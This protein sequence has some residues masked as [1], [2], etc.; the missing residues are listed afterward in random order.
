MR[1]NFSLKDEIS[2]IIL[3]EACFLLLE[4]TLKKAAAANDPT[5]FLTGSSSC[6]KLK[7][8]CVSGALVCYRAST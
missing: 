7:A 1:S 4:L 5:T 6:L 2:R 8:G 3:A